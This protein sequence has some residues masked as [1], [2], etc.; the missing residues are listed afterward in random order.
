MIAL[1][2]FPPAR[3]CAAADLDPQPAR[4]Q[5]LPMSKFTPRE[6]QDIGLQAARR[7]VGDGVEAIDVREGVGSIDEPAYFITYRVRDDDTWR[8]FSRLEDPIFMAI[9]DALL[10]R[11]DE[12]YPF[13][14]VLEPEDWR[15][16]FPLEPA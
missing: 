2:R 6:L 16:V 14:R 1:K 4:P 15:R 3:L 11:E 8:A 12:G 10:E 5:T 9:R 13:I 7:F